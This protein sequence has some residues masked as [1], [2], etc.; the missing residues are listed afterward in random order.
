MTCLRNLSPIHFAKLLA[1]VL[2]SFLAL[3]CTG[4]PLLAIPKLMQL[5]TALMDANPAEFMVALQVDARL[6]P[7]AGAVPL[8]MIKVAPRETGA[9][10]TIDKKLPLQLAVASV[11][12]LGLDAPPNGRRWLIYSLPASTQSELKRIQDFIKARRANPLVKGGGSLSVGV[13]QASLASTDP[14]LA[15]TRWDT[16]LQTT[17]KDGFFEVWSGT[18]AQLKKMAAEPR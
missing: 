3:A 8:L 10:E 7:P 1:V 17:R 2:C 5:N 12:T 11:A 13:E 9:F 15:D 14:A 16:W 18:P 4:V 6:T